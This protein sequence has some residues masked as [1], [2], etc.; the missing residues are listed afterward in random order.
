MRLCASLTPPAGGRTLVAMRGRVVV[1]L[2][3]GLCLGGA[4]AVA[5]AATLEVKSIG[6][7]DEIFYTAG[8]GEANRVVAS[9]DGAVLTVRDPG[10]EVQAGNGCVSVTDHRATCGWMGFVPLNVV[11]KNRADELR[12]GSASIRLIA[13]GGPGADRLRGG[14]L[15]DHFDGG[16]GPDVV[17][18]RGG[19]DVIDY[20]GRSDDLRVTIGDGRR[21]D[22]GSGDGA[23]RD[24]LR[25]ITHVVGGDGDDVL[26]GNAEE[27]EIFGYAGADR[28]RGLGGADS[29]RGGDGRDVIRGGGG[30]DSSQGMKGNDRMLGGRGN[31]VFTESFTPEGADLISG[32]RGASDSAV[33]IYRFDPLLIRLDGKPNDG[34][35]KTP[36]CTASDEGDNLVGI[37]EVTGGGAA[38]RIFGSKRDEY[39]SPANGA[40]FVRA[41]G[42]DDVVALYNDGDIDN[43]DCGP[44][45]DQVVGSPDAF[46]TNVNC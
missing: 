3:C 32:G 14:T 25:S 46:D 45:D 39:L 29:L 38:D 33:Y 43:V 27:N 13:D 36:A 30:A 26:V 35:C 41:R 28:I 6:K 9:T 44:G 37:E 4:P 10:A 22:G 18:G 5:G 19:A 24:R 40:D 11:L 8:G 15:L 12:L 21:N 31:D 2:A 16:R 23:K 34:R 7:N 42:G 17:I 20:T 1:A